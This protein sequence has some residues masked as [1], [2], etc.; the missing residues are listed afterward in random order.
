[1]KKKI[2][3]FALCVCLSCSYV[4][5]QLGYYYGEDF[6]ELKPISDNRFFIQTSNENTIQ[7]LNELI[8]QESIDGNNG[9][10]ICLISEGKYYSSTI[11]IIGEDDYF[12]YKYCNNIGGK[13]VVLPQ[14][15][16]VLKDGFSLDDFSSSIK[17]EN[18]FGEIDLFN[19]QCAIFSFSL[20]FKSSSD[21]LNQ[22]ARLQ[23]I[24]CVKWCQPDMLCDWNSSNS[25]PLYSQQYYINNSNGYDINVTPVWSI[26]EGASNDITVAII[27]S[28]VDASH[29]DLSGNVLNGYTVGNVA[30]K[31]LPITTNNDSCRAHG[32]ACAGIVAAQDNNLGIKG[33]AYGVKILPVNIMPNNITPDNPDGFATNS[34]IAAAIIWAADRADI[35]SCSWGGLHL[36][37][38]VRDAIDYARTYGRH[39]NGCVVTASAGNKYL[40]YL[41]T[42]NYPANLNGVISVGAVDRSGNICSYSQRGS[43][44]DLVAF[45]GDS[46]IVT[47]DMMGELGYN[48]TGASGQLA[49]KNY[50]KKFGGTS[51]ACPQVAGVAA[52]ILSVN[53]F[54]SEDQVRTILRQTARDLGDLGFDTTYGC[55]LVNAYNAVR[56]ASLKIDG[57]HLIDSSSSFSINPFLRDVNIV[58]RLSDTYYD[59]HCIQQ[60]SPQ[61]NQCTIVRSDSYNMMDATLTAT[62]TSNGSTRTIQKDGINAYLGFKGHYSSLNITNEITSPVLNV[63]PNCCTYIYSPNLIGATI[64]YS[65]IGAAPYLSNFLP[66]DGTLVVGV[67][68]NDNNI[69]VQVNITDVCG[70]SHT[71]YLLPYSS[72]Y[73]L[74]IVKQE[75][76]INISFEADNSIINER[77]CI[78][79]SWTCEVRDIR[80]GS[81][82]ANRK[83]NERSVFISTDRW[84]H[85]T[86]LIKIMRGKEI[87][88]HIFLN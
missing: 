36:D 67:S 38:S 48:Y 60:N 69:P 7:V 70:N 64:S 73:I 3:S 80:S 54:L 63:A 9:A 41:N 39:G 79:E 15:L 55:G 23:K 4:F 65:N 12:S 49:N 77:T 75:S 34:Q 33:V 61:Q 10:N 20:A 22:V 24:P 51:A 76:G 28:G 25:N 21:V 26:Q 50:T 44:L 18:I 19:K 53:P 16:F 56:A 87:T 71:L 82:M 47:L 86:Y 43:N 68:G 42:I 13:L 35:L 85:G 46:D 5:S 30:G 45:G 8:Q 84:A 6:I 57:L 27:D 83:T 1:M 59:Q 88:T 11:D 78:N 40:S 29:E 74:N 52:L 81:L 2:I 66:D 58:W 72:Q 17:K 32:T 37:N 31:G 14:I 62:I